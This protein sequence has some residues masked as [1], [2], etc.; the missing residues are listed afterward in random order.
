MKKTKWF[1]T[2]GALIVLGASLVLPLS[3][4]AVD[5]RQDAPDFTLKSLEGSN[6]RLEEYRGQVVLI[7]FWASWCGPCRAEMPGIEDLY[8]DLKNEENIEFVMLS[9]DRNEKAAHKFM[10]RMKFDFPSYTMGGPLTEQL[11]VPSI[12]TTFVISPDGTIIKKKVGLARYNTKA[13][14]KFLLENI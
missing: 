11:R 14:K 9:V 4:L 6:L 12:P 2:A 3:S 8:A 13:F 1:S 7:N 10:K 5:L